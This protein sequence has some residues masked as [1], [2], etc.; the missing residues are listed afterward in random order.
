MKKNFIIIFLCAFVNVNGQ[1]EELKKYFDSVK[2]NLVGKE[3]PN[4]IVID[5]LGSKYDL[6]S[7][8]G[9]LVA[10]NIWV[11]GCSGCEYEIPLLNKLVENYN[12]DVKFIAFYASGPFDF[13]KEF[14][15]ELRNFNFNYEHFSTEKKLEETLGLR[16]LFPT[17]L[18]IDQESNVLD[19]IFGLDVDA[20]EKLL[21]EN[22]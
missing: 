13:T 16:M 22:I 18:V 4:I 7:F 12:N 6:H 10:I 17:H 1:S 9:K 19:V 20:I 8:K 21:K 15:D 2:M 11:I 14:K 5:S 3:I